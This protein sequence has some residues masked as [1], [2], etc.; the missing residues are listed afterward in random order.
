MHLPDMKDLRPL[1][2]RARCAAAVVLAGAAIP[3]AAQPPPVPAADRGTTLRRCAIWEQPVLRRNP[4]ESELRCRYGTEG[5][6][7]FGLSVYMEVPVYQP[8]TPLPGTHVVGVPALP[9]PA[10]GESY[11]A[12]EWRVLRSD[13]GPDVRRAHRGTDVL[14]PTFASRL[15]DFEQHLRN[16]GVR[17]H[18]RE[19]WR[20]PERQAWLFQQGRS[21]PGPLATATLTSWH[22]A[23]DETGRPA[24]AAADYN[25][26]RA[27]MPRFHEIAWMVG[28]ATY[29]PDSNDP[30]HVYLPGAEEFDPHQLQLLRLLPRVPVVT[31]ATGRPTDEVVGR[32][33][34]DAW[35]RA[36]YAFAWEP[37]FPSPRTRLA[38]FPRPVGVRTSPIQSPS[39]I[40]PPPEPRR[41]RH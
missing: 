15:L 41:R 16:A 11:E 26:P 22:S 17:F 35:R 1:R 14:H 38:S 32:A 23:V 8:A 27:H 24:A 39:P 29:G 19:T 31:L 33:D 6:G 28:L 18:R 37:F 30:G 25:V 2:R 13:F 20:S 34:R 12:W 10:P 21:R 9:G 5:P 7:R 36:A 4:T 40:P 3:A